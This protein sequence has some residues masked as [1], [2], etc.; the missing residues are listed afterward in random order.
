MGFRASVRVLALAGGEAE[1]LAAVT[2]SGG[3]ALLRVGGGLLAL[4]VVERN[5]ELLGDGA[6]TQVGEVR[7]Q[8][9]VDAPLVHR[10]AASS[11]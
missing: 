1:G 3:H 11:A 5:G 9:L 2:V 8:L 10:A 4:G 6:E 7:A